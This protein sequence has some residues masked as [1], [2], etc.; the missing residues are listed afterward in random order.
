MT[1]AM[2]TLSAAPSLSIGAD[3]QVQEVG[4]HQRYSLLFKI[5]RLRPGGEI[6]G[7]SQVTGGRPSG[8]RFHVESYSSTS[9]VS[10]GRYQNDAHSVRLANRLAARSRYQTGIA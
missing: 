4:S 5:E 8:I 10:L 7:N 6:E 2:V 9:S 3:T 1:R